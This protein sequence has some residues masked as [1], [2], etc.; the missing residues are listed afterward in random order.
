MEQQQQWAKSHAYECALDSCDEGEFLLHDGPPY[1]NG[2][3][4]MGHALNK[5]LKVR[6]ILIHFLMRIKD[7]S[8]RFALLE[9]RKARL[10]PGWDCHGLPIELKALKETDVNGL[11]P[12]VVREQARKVQPFRAH[13]GGLSNS[14]QFALDTVNRQREGF[15]RLGVWADWQNPYL[16]LLPKYE[17]EQ[18]KKLKVV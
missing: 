12:T 7:F 15:Q 18:V 2:P 13:V 16:T 5:C 1:A 6:I 11:D 14:S 10:V 9:G 8:L 4:H 17:A 3:L